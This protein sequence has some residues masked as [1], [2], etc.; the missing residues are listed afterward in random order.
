MGL[1]NKFY[2]KEEPQL[3]EVKGH[4]LVCPICSNDKFWSR[5]YLLD[6]SFFYSIKIGE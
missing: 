6:N 5:I 3:I 2:K 1:F 4:P